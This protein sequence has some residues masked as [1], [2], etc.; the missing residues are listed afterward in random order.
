MH[1]RSSALQFH[2]CACFAWE[3]LYEVNAFTTGMLVKR[4]E[5]AKKTK[6]RTRLAARRGVSRSGRSILTATPPAPYRCSKC[7]LCENIK[8]EIPRSADYPSVADLG[9]SPLWQTCP[10]E[11]PEGVHL[12]HPARPTVQRLR[13]TL[14]YGNLKGR[15]CSPFIRQVP[16]APGASASFGVACR[17]WQV[18]F[19]WFIQEYLRCNEPAKSVDLA[20]LLPAQRVPSPTG[21]VV[22]RDDD[23]RWH[24]SPPRQLRLDEWLTEAWT[25]GAILPNLDAAELF[26]IV[27]ALYEDS[28]HQARQSVTSQAATLY[29]PVDLR[30]ALKTQWK[31]QLAHVQRIQASLL[32]LSGI[33]GAAKIQADVIKT[34][35]RCFVLK[36]YGGLN[37]RQIAAIVFPKE[38]PSDAA[39]KVRN[40]VSR[41]QKHLSRIMGEYQKAPHLSGT[42][43]QEVRS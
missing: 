11:G 31:V 8:R 20:D 26:G 19:E 18:Q 33:K 22:E 14:Q 15:V 9:D 43:P 24:L 32:A 12:W 38:N 41:L 17:P 1:K 13:F 35:L 25:P 37:A 29:V 36:K 7:G 28:L 27:Q 4:R 30:L 42:P 16:L 5:R 23:G 3:S 39:A 6:A 10:D 34:R 40:E 2:G 21:Q